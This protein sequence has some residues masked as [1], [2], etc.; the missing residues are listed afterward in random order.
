MNVSFITTPACTSSNPAYSP[1]I[2]RSDLLV[3]IEVMALLWSG[4]APGS[5]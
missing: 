2:C 3:E 5:D 1:G 4:S